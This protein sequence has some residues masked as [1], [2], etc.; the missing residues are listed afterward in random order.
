MIVL[1]LIQPSAAM[2]LIAAGDQPDRLRSEAA[3]AHLC[4]AG[5]GRCEN[6]SEV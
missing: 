3:W 1:Q 4:A 6:A 5:P 2:L